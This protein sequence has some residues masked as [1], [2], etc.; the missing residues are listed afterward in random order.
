MR[1][2][3]DTNHEVHLITS[4]NAGWESVRNINVHYLRR[5]SSRLRVINYA[6]NTLPFYFQFKRLLQ[7]IKPDIIHAQSMM[8]ITL[9]PAVCKFHP[10]VITVWGSDI[11]INTKKSIVSKWLAQYALSHADIVTCDAEHIQ[12]TLIKLGVDSRK[13]KLIYF[14]TDVEKFHPK[15]RDSQLRN[16]LGIKELAVISLRNL[17]PIYDVG[18][19]IKS[20]PSVLRVAPRTIFIIAGDG[21]LKEAL[22]ILASSLGV[23]DNIRFVGRL[24]EDE[25]PRYLASSDVY[26]STALSDAGLSASTA[27]AMACELPVVIT[28]FGDNRKWVK[29]GVNG[30]L[31][32]LRSPEML[33][34]KI[35]NLLQ[36]GEKRNKFGW[37][38]RDVIEERNNWRIEMEKMTEVYNEATGKTKKYKCSKC[39]NLTMILNSGI[40]PNHD[41]NWWVEYDCPNCG[42]QTEY[43][44]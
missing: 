6:L 19:L 11:L 22:K 33:T 43:Y 24:K 7:E 44:V 9:L 41:G 3:A 26:V 18:T 42:I 1:Y 8:D 2:F 36:D 17:R 29:D 25:L 37:E 27:E 10:F 4:S 15:Q 30:F 16:E 14:G 40:D 28:D 32:P 5:V 13:I 38:N 12:N 34:E 21:S 20:I 23:L 31:V 35:I 39:G